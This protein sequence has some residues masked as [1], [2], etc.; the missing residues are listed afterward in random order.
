[1]LQKIHQIDMSVLFP[2]NIPYDMAY[3]LC[4]GF[5]QLVKHN[6]YII[7]CCR[8]VVIGWMP[9][10]NPHHG[11]LADVSVGCPGSTSLLFI[12]NR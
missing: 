2:K 5:G 11:A 1:M 7:I 4:S 6:N 9:P 3:L 10:A 12:S 8:Y